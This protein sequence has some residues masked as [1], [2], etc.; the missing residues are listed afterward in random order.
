MSEG[1]APEDVPIIP[2]DLDRG[3]A[4][5]SA[6]RR[7]ERLHEQREQVARDRLGKRLGGLYLALSADAVDSRLGA[8]RAG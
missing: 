2:R 1:R 8:G 4:G 3:T 6:R 5:A 7:Y